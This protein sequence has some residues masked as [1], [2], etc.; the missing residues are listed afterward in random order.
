MNLFNDRVIHSFMHGNIIFLLSFPILFSLGLLPQISTFIMYLCEQ[1]DIHFFGGTAATTGL[2]SAIYCLVRS[3]IAVCF[4]YACACVALVDFNNTSH[5]VMYSIFCGVLLSTSYHLSR[6]SSDPTIYWNLFKKCFSCKRVRDKIPKR[7]TESTRRAENEQCETDS[8]DQEI[9]DPLPAKLETT[10]VRSLKWYFDK[11][12]FKANFFQIM[13]LQSDMIICV[14]IAIIVFAT[15]V[16]TIF[17][18][19]VRFIFFLR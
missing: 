1:I 12:V 19:Q 11:F 9:I 17:S 18:L 5:S 2:P 14:I 15:H 6:S 4:L 8:Q 3:I 13:R 7:N 10:V 16:S